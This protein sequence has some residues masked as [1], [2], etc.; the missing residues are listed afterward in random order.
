MHC[1]FGLFLRKKK[2]KSKTTKHSPFTYLCR[3]TISLFSVSSSLIAEKS[4]TEFSPWALWK[5]KKMFA[6]AAW[7]L[8]SL[9][10]WNT[11]V[12]TVCSIAF[13]TFH[14]KKKQK[15]NSPAAVLTEYTI[16]PMNLAIQNK[17]VSCKFLKARL[18]Q[19]HTYS[20]KKSLVL[21][22]HLFYG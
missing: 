13:Q 17:F 19:K 21:K 9:Y 8:P 5:K 14:C 3:S 20:Y 18:P 16:C 6:Y 1:F 22:L 4:A 10:K 7:H 15:N 11:K 2:A 12:T